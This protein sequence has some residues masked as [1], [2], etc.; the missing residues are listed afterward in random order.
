MITV[1]QE[2][3]SAKLGKVKKRDTHNDR[4]IFTAV[5]SVYRPEMHC[6]WEMQQMVGLIPAPCQIDSG[7]KESIYII[8]YIHNLC[9]CDNMKRPT[10]IKLLMLPDFVMQ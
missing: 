9:H 1:S 6:L 10:H 2:I 5:V 7:C 8:A 4:R 3:L